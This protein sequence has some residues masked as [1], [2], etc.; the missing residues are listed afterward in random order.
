M[1]IKVDRKDR[2]LLDAHYYELAARQG[3]A[4]A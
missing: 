2:G 4:V 3:L 1:F